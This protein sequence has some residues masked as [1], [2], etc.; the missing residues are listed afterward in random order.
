[1]TFN[2][3]NGSVI[4]NITNL[5]ATCAELIIYCNNTYFGNQ[6]IW[7]SCIINQYGNK[8]IGTSTTDDSPSLKLALIISILGLFVILVGGYVCCKNK[9]L[10]QGKNQNKQQNQ[11]HNT[12]TLAY[13]TRIHRIALPYSTSIS[14]SLHELESEYETECKKNSKLEPDLESGLD[15]GLS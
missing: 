13:L 14:P 6:D 8:C 3:S 15:L 7:C 1:M 9:I 2:C 5:G 4:G 10:C 11:K 12:W